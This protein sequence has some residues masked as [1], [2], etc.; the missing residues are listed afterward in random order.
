MGRQTP[1]PAPGK[2]GGAVKPG[3]A[4]GV[5]APGAVAG[6]GE[7][8]AKRM[9]AEKGEGAPPAEVSKMLTGLKYQA[10]IGNACA[11]GHLETYFGLGAAEKVRFLQQWSSEPKASRNLCRWTFSLT[12]T[13]EAKS[14]VTTA[15]TEITLFA[16]QVLQEAGLTF[17]DFAT[18]EEALEFLLAFVKKN[19]AEHGHA[20]THTPDADI[21]LHK[22]LFHR[23]HGTTRSSSTGSTVQVTGTAAASAEVAAEAVKRLGAEEQGP[24]APKAEDPV[25]QELEKALAVLSS[26]LAALQGTLARAEVLAGKLTAR[27]RS[28][29]ALKDKAG[30]FALGVAG[31]RT[32]LTAALV[33]VAEWQAMPPGAGNL[34]AVVKEVEAIGT[35]ASHKVDA[36]RTACKKNTAF[37]S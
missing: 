34:E 6:A 31:D 14:S 32:W 15:A 29:A 21:R 35:T 27:S 3:G 33:Q 8:P 5:G 10:G 24:E 26:T 9:K 7:P 1:K 25:H 18:K 20:G 12:K 11:A 28:D 19:A 2:R 22:F 36:L 37:V 17:T 13:L 23:G 16:G 4:K 30:Q